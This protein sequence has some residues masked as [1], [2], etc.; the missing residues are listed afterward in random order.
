[1]GSGSNDGWQLNK[2]VFMNEIEIYACISGNIK[3][4]IELDLP[5]AKNDFLDGLLTGKYATTIGH[6][7]NLGKVIEFHPVHGI[8]EIGR[9]VEQEALDD[10]E[11]NQ[12][13]LCGSEQ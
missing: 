12:F 3:Q 7:S 2:I 11:I 6:G 13:E 9:V 5:I 4:V 10:V 1:V 8:R